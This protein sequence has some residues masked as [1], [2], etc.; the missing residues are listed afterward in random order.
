MTALQMMWKI[1]VSLNVKR[2]AANSNNDAVRNNTALNEFNIIK[3]CLNKQ[4]VLFLIGNSGS[5]L[6]L[7]LQAILKTKN[8]K[9]E[10]AILNNKIKKGGISMEERMHSCSSILIG[11]FYKIKVDLAI[12]QH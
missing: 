2:D 4:W 11:L 3:T 1:Q 8:K 10:T 9:N 12:Q 5:C 7:H 6:V